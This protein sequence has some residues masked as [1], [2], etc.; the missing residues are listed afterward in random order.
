MRFNKEHLD[1]WIS[2]RVIKIAGDRKARVKIPVHLEDR[3][4]WAAGNRA[5]GP[6]L[7]TLLALDRWAHVTPFGT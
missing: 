2:P 7:S 3:Q 4:A 5:C 1:I 6:L